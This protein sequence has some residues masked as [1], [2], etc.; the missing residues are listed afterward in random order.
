MRKLLFLTLAFLL[1]ACGAAATPASAPGIPSEL[2]PF[3]GIVTITPEVGPFNAPVVEM[4]A[5]PIPLPSPTRISPRLQASPTRGAQFTATLAETATPAPSDTPPGPTPTETL[6]PPLE[7]PP[8]KA[9]MPSRVAWTGEP[10]YPGDSELGLLFRVDYDPD[11]WAQTEGNYGEIVLAH[12]NIPY[13]TLSTWTGR[14][15]PGGLQVEHEFRT[16][17]GADFDVNTVTQKDNVQFVT[18]V[19]GDRRILTG[20]QVSFEQQKDQCLQDAELILG[21][22]RSLAAI[23]TATPNITPASSAPGLSAG[24]V[25][26]TP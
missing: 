6:L 21:T 19:G 16:I 20:F 9:F 14:G 11:T 22:L 4:T 12:R 15:L 8:L 25:T 24:N 10:T 5:T 1:T 2:P 23:P 26:P 18:Y 7:L 3:P 17:G 13:C